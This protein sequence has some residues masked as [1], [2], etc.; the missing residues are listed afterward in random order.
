MSYTCMFIACSSSP[1]LHDGTCILDSSYTYHCACLA[2]Y[3]GQRCENGESV[4]TE[5]SVV[6]S[7]LKNAGIVCFGGK[8]KWGKK[9]MPAVSNHGRIKQSHTVSMTW[10]FHLSKYL[11]DTCFTVLTLTKF[12][13]YFSDF[14]WNSDTPSY[15]K[16][17]ENWLLPESLFYVAG[18]AAQRQAVIHCHKGEVCGLDWVQASC[19]PRPCSPRYGFGQSAVQQ[20]GCKSKWPSNKYVVMKFSSIEPK[21]SNSMRFGSIFMRPYKNT[22]NS[23][24]WRG[25]QGKR[26][27]W[28][29]IQDI[30]LM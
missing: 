5:A 24:L 2:G 13:N 28:L 19:L 30:E 7:R 9:E 25:W 3:T 11:K 23:N 16:L 21:Q 1:C 20:L 4:T 15:N 12:Q 27:L 14:L 6:W 18:V 29:R 10:V 26:W 22:L 17:I 8:W